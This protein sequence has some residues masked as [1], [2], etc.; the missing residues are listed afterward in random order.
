[1]ES[2]V[3]STSDSSNLQS[4]PLNHHPVPHQQRTHSR[5]NMLAQL[6]TGGV[7]QKPMTGGNL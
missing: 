6:P 2:W 7:D 4:T 1:M 5:A 3:P